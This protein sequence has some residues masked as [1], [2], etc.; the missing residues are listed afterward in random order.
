MTD[1]PGRADEVAAYRQA[2]EAHLSRL[3]AAERAE[4]LADLEA[5]LGEVAAELELESSLV[6]RLGTPAD[7]AK[8]LREAVRVSSEQTPAQ[9]IPGSGGPG[10][11]GAFVPPAFPGIAPPL[12]APPRRSLT[13]LWIGLGVGAGTLVMVL[14]M[15]FLFFGAPFV[16]DDGTVNYEDLPEA[17]VEESRSEET[18]EATTSESGSSES[19]SPWDPTSEAEA[20]PSELP[21]SPS[22]SETP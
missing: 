11:Q 22:E 13:G 15:G 9:G 7:Y 5:H 12:V 16:S 20:T 18:A 10:G 19:E 2:V 17:T 8:E 6:G 4:L 14:A 1:N 3:P 21:P